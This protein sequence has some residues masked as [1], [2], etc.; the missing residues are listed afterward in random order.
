MNTS[1]KELRQITKLSQKEFGQKY[2]IPLKTIQNW[3]SS[4]EKPS[5]RIC[6]SYIIYLLAKIIVN[7]YPNCQ[8][9]DKLDNLIIS[10]K[11]KLDSRRESA[12]RYALQKITESPLFPYV[13]DVIL[14]GSTARNETKKSSDI[15]LLLVLNPKIKNEAKH[16]GWIVK[17][18]GGISTENYKDPETDL[19]IAYGD[20]W[21]NENRAFQKNILTEGFS[22]WN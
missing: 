7:E 17:I 14:Y 6:P 19:H 15:D 10:G 18:K 8:L 3:E 13:D 9:K 16:S 1:I 5:S 21:K 12:L 22:I 20:F 4:T 2:R 11:I